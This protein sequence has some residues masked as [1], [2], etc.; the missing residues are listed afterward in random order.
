VIWTCTLG[1]NGRRFLQFNCVARRWLVG[2]YWPHVHIQARMRR[3]PW[4][5]IVVLDTYFPNS[6]ICL[7]IHF[8]HPESWREALA[9]A[10]RLRGPHADH[11]DQCSGLG[12][13]I[14][15]QTQPRATGSGRDASSLGPLSLC[16]AVKGSTF[17]SRQELRSSQSY[18]RPLSSRTHVGS[19]SP[20]T[21]NS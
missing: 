20:A 21:V 17:C 11:L 7:M 6:P 3:Y 8:G 10:R 14:L 15:A 12:H 16:D 2:K 19:Q 1:W 18:V 13:D 5:R 9:I 4:M